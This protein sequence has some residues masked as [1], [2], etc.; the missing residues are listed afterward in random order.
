MLGSNR[1][2]HVIRLGTLCIRFWMALGRLDGLGP[3]ISSIPPSTAMSEIAAGRICV[4]IVFFTMAAAHVSKQRLNAGG[5]PC[6]R[7]LNRK[8]ARHVSC[9]RSHVQQLAR[10]HRGLPDILGVLTEAH[11]SVANGQNFSDEF[12]GVFTIPD[13]SISRN[14]G[15]LDT[16]IGST[17]Q[18]L[19]RCGPRNTQA[20][21]EGHGMTR[22]QFGFIL[23]AVADRLG[24]LLGMQIAIALFVSHCSGIW[25]SLR[26]NLDLASDVAKLTAYKAALQTI[27]C[28][29][30]SAF[31]LDGIT[32][33]RVQRRGADTF[34]VPNNCFASHDLRLGVATVAA[35]TIFAG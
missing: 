8:S 11:F 19:Y 3:H 33:E 12:A 28:V 20:L 23:V 22:L 2:D 15:V 27:C 21:R 24:L 35:N 29:N 25:L 1:R 31:R 7:A 26:D 6:A 10:C 17:C 18:P 14:H 13:S 30:H 32:G 4:A 16:V 9:A 5:F 34:E